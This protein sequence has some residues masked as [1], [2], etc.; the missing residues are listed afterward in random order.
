MS[1]DVKYEK[2]GAVRLIDNSRRVKM[3]PLGFGAND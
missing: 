3:H 2:H 1:K